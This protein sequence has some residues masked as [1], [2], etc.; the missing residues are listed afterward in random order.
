[1]KF[2]VFKV[3][4]RS[5]RKLL[6]YLLLGALPLKFC[7]VYAIFMTKNWDDFTHAVKNLVI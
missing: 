1:M 4:Q 6:N 5:K 3:S 2:I 7:F